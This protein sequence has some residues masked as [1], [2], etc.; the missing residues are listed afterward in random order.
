MMIK[1]FPLLVALSALL[2]VA[3][4]TPP[5][6]E[7]IELPDIIFIDNVDTRP[8]ILSPQEALLGAAQRNRICTPALCA[9]VCAAL[10]F[11]WSGCNVNRVC[12]CRR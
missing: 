12:V 3:Q 4:A 10:G 9:H 11:R 7:T 8:T 5:A 2:L 1:T 6:S